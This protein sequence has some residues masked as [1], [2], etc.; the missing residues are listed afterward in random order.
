LKVGNLLSEN[1]KFVLPLDSK[2]LCALSVLQEP[3]IESYDVSISYLFS[4]LDILMLSG[5]LDG[6]LES[7]L[8]CLDWSTLSSSLSLRELS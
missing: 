7:V 5:F 3:T 6:I 1:V 2:P 4:C 8:D